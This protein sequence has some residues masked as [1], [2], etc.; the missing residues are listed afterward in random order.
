MKKQNMTSIKTTMA[1]TMASREGST[2]KASHEKLPI[3]NYR[4]QSLKPLVP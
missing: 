2:R 4:R 1:T 3:F